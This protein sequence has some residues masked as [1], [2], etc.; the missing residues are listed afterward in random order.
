M[1]AGMRV[2]NFS[3]DFGRPSTVWRLT[4]QDGGVAWLKHHEHP[5]LYQRELLG[6]EQFVPALG[7]QHWWSAPALIAK[8]DAIEAILMSDV[9]GQILEGASASPAELSEMFRLAG[10]FSALLHNLEVNAPD[11][12]STKEYLS[13]RLSYYLNEGKDAVA[14]SIVETAEA[15]IAEACSHVDSRRVACHMDYSPRNWLLQ[16]SAQGIRL[17]VI[18]WERARYDSWLQDI[19]R[20]AYDWFHRE[21][22]LGDAFYQGYGRDL[23]ARETIQLDAICLVTAIA[24]IPW[25]VSHN[26][27]QF[28]SL[29][30]HQIQIICSNSGKFAPIA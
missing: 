26:D 22:H 10:R 5:R 23:T 3:R 27:R 11:G 6:L 7:E 4:G 19:Q 2:E 1:G 21:P 9:N 18:D 30:R 24:S 15:M 17:G 14:S 20:M 12:L 25:A 16:R 28:E 29:S 8:D 13:D